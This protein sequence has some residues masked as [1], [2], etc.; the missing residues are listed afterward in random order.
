MQLIDGIKTKKLSLLPDDRGFLMEILR[1]DWP[2]YD[3][4]GQVYVTACYPGI[5]KAWHYHKIQWDHFVCVSGMAKVVLYDNREKSKT[6]GLVNEFYIGELNPMLIKIPPNI[7]H[8]F[9]TAGEKMAL[10]INVPTELYNYDNPDEY[11]VEYNDPS[12]PYSW[13]VKHG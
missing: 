13:E 12:I 5:I 8:G 4:F 3:R 11:R 10:I 9:T 6:K 7:Y 1:S 2:E